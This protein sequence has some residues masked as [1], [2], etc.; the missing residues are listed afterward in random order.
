MPITV[1]DKIKQKNNLAF[2]IIDASDINWDIDIPSESLPDDVYTKNEVDSAIQQAISNAPHIKRVVL[3]QS[4]ELPSSPDTNTIYMKPKDGVSGSNVYEEW[5]YINGSWEQLGDSSV[6]LSDY[7][8]SGQL[9][10]TTQTILSQAEQT[11]QSIGG[12]ALANAKAYVDAEKLKYLPLSG[13]TMMGKITGI[14]TPTASTDA[15]NKEYVDAVAAG[16][17]PENMLTPN[18]ITT[19][20][21]NGTI[22][23]KDTDVAVKGLGSAAYEDASAFAVVWNDIV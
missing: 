12:E 21:T 4:E 13:G 8:T 5:M 23:V 15:A 11:A 1:I 19:G 6:D 2:K 9:S 18:D 3:G 17:T 7:V 10:S 16:V 14:P 20:T 22:K